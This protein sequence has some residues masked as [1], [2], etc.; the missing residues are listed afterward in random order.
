MH[1]VNFVSEGSNRSGQ[2]NRVRKRIPCTY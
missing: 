1:F 2:H